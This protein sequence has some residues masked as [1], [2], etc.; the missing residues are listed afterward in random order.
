MI[1]SRNNAL[2]KVKA[3]R[4]KKI[5]KWWLIHKKLLKVKQICGFG[6]MVGQTPFKQ[7]NVSRLVTC[8]FTRQGNTIL[9][10]LLFPWLDFFFLDLRSEGLSSLASLGRQLSFFS[11]I[12]ESEKFPRGKKSSSSFVFLPWKL[13]S[14]KE[15]YIFCSTEQCLEQKV[16]LTFKKS[17]LLWC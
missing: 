17:Q 4:L 12:A 14:I 1:N 10:K 13:F 8:V 15:E 6:L 9:D 3:T 2:V 7:K 11:T 16:F 5:S